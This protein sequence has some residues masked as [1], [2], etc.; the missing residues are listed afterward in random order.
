MKLSEKYTNFYPIYVEDVLALAADYRN[1]S[2]YADQLY[3]YRTHPSMLGLYDS[4]QYYYYSTK[5]LEADFGKALGR[6]YH[7]FPEA[8]TLEV[9]TFISEFGNKAILYPGGIGI[10]LDMFLGPQYPYYKGMQIPNFIIR[11]LTKEQILPN[12]MRVLAEDYVPELP[13][14]A[15]LLDVMIMEGKRLYFAEQMLPNTPKH[16]IIEYSEDQ[17]DWCEDN[18]FNIWGSFI[19]GNLLYNTKFVEYRRYVEEGPTTMGLPPESPSKIGIWLGWQI[20][21]EYMG[22][23][24]GTSLDELLLMNDSQEL[25]RKSK[26]KPKV[27]N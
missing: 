9:V 8:E 18:E 21:N 23:N 6:Y 20:V 17:Y 22:R 19:E 5:S 1:I 26:Y 3:S 12:A 2:S 25:L 10:S 14:N 7:F 16:Q 13:P 24:K 27:A 11:N 15:T 4:I